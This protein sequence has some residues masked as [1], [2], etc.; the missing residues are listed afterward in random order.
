MAAAPSAATP[1][2]DSRGRPL[3]DLRVSVTDRCNFRCTYCMPRAHFDKDFRFLPSSALLSFE[4]IALV[5]RLFVASGV[6][7]IRLTGGEPL[8]RRHL[9]RLVELL[10]Q[11]DGVDLAVTTNGTLLA[12]KAPALARA[13]LR[14]ATISLD[15]LDDDTFRRTSDSTVSVGHVLRGIEAAAEAGLGPLKINTVVRRGVND[16]EIVDIARHFRGTGH[17]VRF[18]EFMDVGTTNLWN[19]TEVV[20]GAEIV[21]R[22]GAEF[23]LEPLEPARPGEV[24]RRYRYADGAG[25]IGVIT[26]VTA[27]FCGDCTRARLSSEGR[28]FTC[29]FATTG[30]DLRELVRG[31]ADDEELRAAI[32]STW[33]RRDDRYSELRNDG[34]RHL[35]RI[36]MSYIGG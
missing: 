27:P 25:E 29:L 3:R 35:P 13:G 31:G 12:E 4:E 9:E 14:R 33:Q 21:A 17:I 18:I 5:A 26:S 20:S 6:Q 8:L 30:T 32:A 19:R 1:L 7:K 2:L 22:I 24:A 11:N 16:H 10:A 23:P 36:E 15:S 28:L 34:K